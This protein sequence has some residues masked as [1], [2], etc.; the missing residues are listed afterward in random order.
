VASVYSL[1]PLLGIRAADMALVISPLRDG[2]I[3]K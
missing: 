2:A 1:E 3:F